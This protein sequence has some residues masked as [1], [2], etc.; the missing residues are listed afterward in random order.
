MKLFVVSDV[1]GYYDEMR[2]ALLEAGFDEKNPN[3]MLISCGDNWDRGS[4]PYE[5]MDYLTHL[6]R[7]ALVRGNHEDLLNKMLARHSTAAED[8]WNGTEDTFYALLNHC[9]DEEDKSM[10]RLVGEQMVDPFFSQMVDYYETK[11]YIFVH[12]YIPSDEDWRNG[13]WAQAR[14]FNGFE[15]AQHIQGNKTNKTIVFGHWH[16]SYG[17]LRIGKGMSDF[18]PHADFSICEWY[19]NTIGIDACTAYSKKVNVLVVEDELLNGEAAEIG[20]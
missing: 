17:N 15:H 3:H 5:V 14:W 6:E 20:D 8:I 2:A 1:H 19:N 7:K 9:E 11:N 18:G 10:Y 12:G 4:K 13:N 16:C